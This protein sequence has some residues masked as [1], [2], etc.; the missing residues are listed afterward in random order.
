VS[1]V[2][3]PGM[4]MLFEIISNSVHLITQAEVEIKSAVLTSPISP[5]I[6]NSTNSSPFAS[7]NYRNPSFSRNP[8]YTISR[9]LIMWKYTLEG[10]N[11][12]FDRIDLESESENNASH[13]LFCIS[14]YYEDLS[15]A[16]VNSLLIGTMEGGEIDAPISISL[17]I[18]GMKVLN[19]LVVVKDFRSALYRHELMDILMSLVWG[20][21]EK[22]TKMVIKTIHRIFQ[23]GKVALT[24]LLYI[25]RIG[26][27]RCPNGLD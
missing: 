17:A 3:V 19:T 6:D 1:D 2:I 21:D 13:I 14:D 7:L 24:R 25:F 22:L 8:A 27:A 23:Y 20:I 26:F 5:F 15:S 16:L 18:S 12:L 9:Q 10:L 4:H 11:I